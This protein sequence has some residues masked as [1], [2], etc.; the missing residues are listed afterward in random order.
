MKHISGREYVNTFEDP[1]LLQPTKWKSLWLVQS[2]QALQAVAGL[3]VY[4][5]KA[6]MRWAHLS[7]TQGQTQALPVV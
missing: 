7:G 1:P 3:R 6:S 2:G 5:G 4:F